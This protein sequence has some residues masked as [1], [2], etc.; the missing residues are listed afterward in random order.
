MPGS[1]PSE[2]EWREIGFALLS[3]VPMS[4]VIQRYRTT[5]K[6]VLAGIARFRE[7]GS[8]HAPKSTGGRGKIRRA[9][10]VTTEAQDKLVK[11][12]ITK[13]RGSPL[14]YT[15]QMVKRD[16]AKAK[17]PTQAS[18]RSLNRRAN[19]AGFGRNDHPA[20][21]EPYSDQHCAD[22]LAYAEKHQD[23]DFTKV[24]L[25][26]MYTHFTNFRVVKRY[27]CQI[28]ILSSVQNVTFFVCRK[29]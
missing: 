12:L 16:L 5:E 25:E 18:S 23:V 17:M 6:T 19:E 1:G 10:R 28:V 24:A 3:G 8:L 9:R 26:R 29:V 2:E 27:F 20:S 22:R 7:S 14:E 21:K 15:A 13:H 4:T 11:K